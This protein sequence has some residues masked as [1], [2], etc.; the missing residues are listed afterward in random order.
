MLSGIVADEETGHSVGCDGP[1]RMQG[2]SRSESFWLPDP[3][4][5]CKMLR[6]EDCWGS[7]PVI[8]EDGKGTA[9]GME[10]DLPCFLGSAALSQQVE[11]CT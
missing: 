6:Q 1:I 7:S 5:E 11:P 3:E 4:Q 9:V 8:Q 10:R 2:M